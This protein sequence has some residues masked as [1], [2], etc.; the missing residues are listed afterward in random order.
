MDSVACNIS[1]T[2]V[3]RPIFIYFVPMRILQEKKVNVKNSSNVMNLMHFWN[4][5]GLNNRISNYLKDS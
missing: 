5:F 3:P 2:S 1:R 4:M